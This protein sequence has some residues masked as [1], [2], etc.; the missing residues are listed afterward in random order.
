MKETDIPLEHRTIK[1]DNIAQWHYEIMWE[2]VKE[3][4]VSSYLLFIFG[5]YILDPEEQSFL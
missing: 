3:E 2:Q 5:S 4:I 1:T